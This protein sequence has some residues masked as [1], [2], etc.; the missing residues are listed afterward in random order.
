MSVRMSA[1]CRRR[2]PAHLDRTSHHERHP[3]E[4]LVL[5]VIWCVGCLRTLD[6]Q[7][8]V[9]FLSL[10][11][12]HFASEVSKCYLCYRMRAPTQLLQIVSCDSCEVKH[13][14]FI[15]VEYPTRVLRYKVD[16]SFLGHM[17]DSVGF[18]WGVCGL[19]W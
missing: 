1:I 18:E 10:L 16:P 3:I 12:G 4:G 15:S 13:F 9:Y 6:G 19:I 11:E 7:I 2:N 14:A 5:T 17:R 8:S